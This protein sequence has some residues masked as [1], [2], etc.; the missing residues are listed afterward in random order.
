M[1]LTEGVKWFADAFLQLGGQWSAPQTQVVA[2]HIL[3]HCKLRQRVGNKEEALRNFREAI[4]YSPFL[5]KLLCS[6]ARRVLG[7]WL[8]DL[9]SLLAGTPCIR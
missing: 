9:T 3:V 4:K 2:R 5:G 7:P 8:H 6:E 1:A